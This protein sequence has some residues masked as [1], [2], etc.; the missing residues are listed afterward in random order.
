M[1][2]D[3]LDSR[4]SGENGVMMLLDM[5]DF[6]R[7]NQKE[8]NVFADTILQEV[9]DVLLAETGPDQIQ[10]RLGGDEFMLFIKNC[11]KSRASVIGPRIAR[12]VQDI[13]ADTKW[14]VQVSAS[15]GMCSTEVTW[16][17]NSLYRCAESTLKYVKENGKGQAACYLNTSNAVGT[18]LTQL[19][20]DEYLVNEIEPENTRAGG[21]L[22]SF[23]LDLLGK[24]K[25]LDD[26]VNLLLARIGRT[27]GFDRVSIIEANRAYLT[28]RF[29]YQWARRRADIQL[30]QE[31]YVSNEDFEL[32]SDMYDEDGLADHNLREGISDIASCLHAGIW[33][34]GEYVGSMS[35]EVDREGFEWTQEYRKLLKE[36]VKIVPSFIMKSKADAVSQA[37]TDFLSRMSHEIRTPMNAISGMTTIAKSVVNDPVKTLDCLEKIELSNV[38]LLIL[39]TIFWIC[40]A[41]RAESWN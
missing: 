6:E 25:N 5:D 12:L 29:S 4:P 13:L 27:C 32:C 15:I 2:Q 30:G 8:G 21:D 22:I 1:V 16:D 38:Y 14:G 7:I 39:L 40:P 23:A 41:S 9:A 11:D 18:F 36:L 3:Y 17:Y 28:Y 33:D 26:A 10:I 35:F 24:A 34:Y 20:T 31:F 37:K 19:Y